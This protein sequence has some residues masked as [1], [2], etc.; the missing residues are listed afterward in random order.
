MEE[1][2]VHIFFK[3]GKTYVSGL[4]KYSLFS[5]ICDNLWNWK[6]WILA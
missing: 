4:F 1:T 2:T 5:C 6:Y 3:Y